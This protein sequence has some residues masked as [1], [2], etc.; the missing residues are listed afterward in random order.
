MGQER[1]GG[2]SEGARWWRAPRSYGCHDRLDARGRGA[3]AR[4]RKTRQKLH[5]Y[6]VVGVAGD[7]PA[8][9]IAGVGKEAVDTRH[10]FL[11]AIGVDLVFDFIVFLRN[12]QDASAMDGALG[13]AQF[14]A[15]DAQLVPGKIQKVQKQEEPEEHQGYAAYQRLRGA[16]GAGMGIHR[17]LKKSE[18]DKLIIVAAGTLA[19]Y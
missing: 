7:I 17:R 18:K 16:A 11:R 8:R 9:A 3:S 1:E 10:I 5:R 13:G 19:K 14:R 6:R 4:G 12:G 15:E 2:E